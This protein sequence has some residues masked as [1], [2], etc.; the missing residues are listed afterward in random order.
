MLQL[1]RRWAAE[2][3]KR[4]CLHNP[5]EREASQRAASCNVK[6]VICSLSYALEPVPCLERCMQAS[7]DKSL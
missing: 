7:Q 1:L 3:R 6:S 2:R 5:R 4:R